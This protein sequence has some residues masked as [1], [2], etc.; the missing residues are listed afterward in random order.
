MYDYKNK[1]A[2]GKNEIEFIN[3]VYKFRLQSNLLHILTGKAVI[4]SCLKLFY[5]IL[6][7]NRFSIHYN[8][9]SFPNIRSNFR[10]NFQ[11]F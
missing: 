3:I 5:L 11:R 8:I 6:R 2:S 7:L 9:N 1:I 10:I 4:I